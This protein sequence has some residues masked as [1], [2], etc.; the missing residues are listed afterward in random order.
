[1][2]PSD[3]EAPLSRRRLLQASAA[4][5]AGLPFAHSPAQSAAQAAAAPSAADP[6]GEGPFNVLF[7]CVDDLNDWV[8]PLGGHPQVQTPNLDRLARRACVFA[9]AHCAGPICNPS[10]AALLTGRH[11]VST[12]LHFLAPTFRET[13]VLA[14]A[15]T[16]PQLF[17]SAGYQTMAVGK[18]FHG[19]NDPASFPEF[20]GMPA[21]YGPTPKTKLSLPKGHPLWD[22]GPYW[23]DLT[24]T[25]DHRIADW[26]VRKLRRPHPAEPFFLAAGFVRP[27]VPMYAPQAFFDLYPQGQTHLPPVPPEPVPVSDYARRLTHA[28]AAPR[29]EYVESEGQLEHAVRSY[30]ASV[31]FVDSQIGRV[32]DALDAS[33]LAGRTHV[34]L[35]ADHGIHLGERNRFGKRSLWERS[36][37]VPLIIAGPGVTPG[38]SHE[39]VSLCDVYPTLAALAGLTPPADLDGQNL[40]FLLHGEPTR[41]GTPAAL[42]SFGPGNHALRSR[43]YR[44]IHYADGSEELYDH[45]SDPHE[46]HNLAEDPAHAA[47]LHQHRQWLPQNEAPL[48]PNSAGSDSPLYT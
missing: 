38:V 5:L 23:D 41:T 40:D 8:G 36:T 1:M 15:V 29:F 9:N 30:L 14:D 4:A 6:V 22:W 28:G 31:S 45:E 13:D 11:P 18:V 42:T 10:R 12:G 32:L 26:A 3:P 20:G 21:S 46:W 17:A 37:R 25:P 48:V 39:P 16:L 47:V 34:V 35:W 44:Y 43:R 2:N 33:G 19:H 27:H 24:D 7:I